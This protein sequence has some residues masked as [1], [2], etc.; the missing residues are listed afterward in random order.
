MI[1]RRAVLRAAGGSLG[2]LYVASLGGCASVRGG[3]RPRAGFLVGHRHLVFDGA[4]GVIELDSARHSIRFLD[5]SER[6]T[7]EIT[8]LGDGPGEIN[9][10]LE[11][12]RLSADS[13]LV[14]DHGNSRLQRFERSGDR[15]V[16]RGTFGDGDAPRLPQDVLVQAGRVYVCDTLGHR[17]L[18][19]DASGRRIATFES[20][21]AP[22]EAE[23]SLNG[24]CGL[25]LGEN[26]ELHVVNKGHGDV[27]VLS[28]TG[29]P[30]R[31]YAGY[32][33]EPGQLLAPAAILIAPDGRVHVADPVACN[34]SSFLQDGRFL[35][36]FTPRNQ[37]GEAVIPVGLALL[38]DGTVYVRA[39]DE[40]PFAA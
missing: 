16:P 10:P 40:H 1:E 8:A 26:G 33:T 13:L 20:T 19:Y 29:T 9:Y 39:A 27:Q 23:G 37:A 38:P 11:V 36:R 15:L 4:N 17:I 5:G 18:V 32:G 28:S 35:E 25:A 30:L 24:P 2:L 12:A 3:A 21:R 34:V 7:A 6:V 31:T 14:L 22:G